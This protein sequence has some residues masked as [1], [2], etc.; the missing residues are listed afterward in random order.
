M[1]CLCLQTF[2]MIKPDGVARNLIAPI[3]D[4]FVQKVG[5]CFQG[6]W[7]LQRC[8]LS[9]MFQ[10]GPEGS[11]GPKVGTQTC[12][13]WGAAARPHAGQVTAWE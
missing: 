13:A 12:T 1:L 11:Q 8:T 6:I 3:L 10:R 5:R 9:G 7:N 4:R 2:V